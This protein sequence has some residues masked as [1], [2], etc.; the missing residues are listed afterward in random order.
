MTDAARRLAAAKAAQPGKVLANPSGWLFLVND[1]NDFLSWQ[2]GLAAWSE[3]ERLRV[4]E[5]LRERVRRLAPVPYLMFVCPEKSVVYR[6]H[7]PMGLD[8]LA[9][10]PDRPACA[11]AR[12]APGVV[13][14]VADHLERLKPL[15]RL[16]F[17]GDTHVNWH[18]AFYLY[19]YA[20]QAARA[21]GVAVAPPLDYGQVR[22]FLG[23]MEG[24]LFVQLDEAQRAALAHL[25]PLSQSHGMFEASVAVQVRPQDQKAHPVDPPADYLPGGG[26]E[27]LI[28]EQ[29][30]RSLP[31]ALVFRDSTATLSVDFLAEH[32]S[33]SVFVW[34]HGDV[35]EDLVERERPDVILHF[36]AERFLATYPRTVPLSRLAELPPE[37][38]TG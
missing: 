33:R 19:R 4:G 26:R 30:D 9:S 21:A 18:G 2:F 35:I 5:I 11:M 17:R 1:A 25:A 32:F 13:H 16:Y 24:D 27:L 14:Y 37:P 7:L 8:G 15:E 20:V 6:E 31:R 10:S 29:G 22:L 36:V 38:P 12:M 23:G 3:A 28:R 34:R